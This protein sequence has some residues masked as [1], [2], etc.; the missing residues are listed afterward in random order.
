MTA[1]IILTGARVRTFDPGGDPAGDGG[2]AIAIK[3][4]RIL[5]VGSASD[6]L[7]LAGPATETIDVSGATIIP[8]FNDTHAHMDREGLKHRRLSLVGA[9]TIAD[10]LARI[11]EAAKKTPAGQWI[12]TMPVGE[13]P[14]YFGGPVYLA[15]GRMPDRHELDRVAPDHPVCISAAFGNW[16]K[17]PC[18]TALNTQA[19]RLNGIDRETSPAC[20]GVEI[21]RDGTGEPTGVIIEANP[22]PTIDNDL[23]TAVP[24]FSYEDRREGLVDSM[25]LYNA[26]GTTSVY[27]GHGLAPRT[28]DAFREL[29]EQGRLTTRVGLVL[30]PTW[31]NAAEARAAIDDWQACAQGRGLDDPWFRICGLHVAF[32]GDAHTAALSRRSLPDAGWAGFVEQANDDAAFLNYAMLCAEFDIRL[33]TIVADNLHRVVPLLEKVAE[34]YDLKGRRW[35]IEHVAR[36][37]QEDL[38][39]LK[40]L[41]MLVTT[42]PVYYLWKGGAAYLADADGGDS[43]VPHRAMLEAGLHVAAGTDNIPYD[44]AFTLWTMACRQERTTGRVLGSSQCL[45]GEEAVRLLTVDGAQLTFDEHKKGPLKP[46][47][48]A[49]LAVLDSDPGLIAPDALRNLKCLLTMVD[50][51]IVHRAL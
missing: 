32:G 44:P 39:A 38:A 51:R 46:G 40:R 15:E 49:D 31:E 43:V 18:F 35:V 26:V 2:E 16:G 37:R 4:N 47:Y 17:P 20:R 34:R 9:R 24:R 6:I 50:G 42:I 28:I 14:F 48:L 7:G 3:S 10:V 25:R 36:C 27:E 19:L 41:D 1:D 5:A 33:H 8:G 45:S 22:R 30:S 12:V 23:L 21:V 13:P 29:W 11:A